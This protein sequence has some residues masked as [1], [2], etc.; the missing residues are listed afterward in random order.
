MELT[1][2]SNIMIFWGDDISLAKFQ[3]RPALVTVKNKKK[4]KPELYYILLSSH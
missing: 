1:I 4:E 3:Y 2:F